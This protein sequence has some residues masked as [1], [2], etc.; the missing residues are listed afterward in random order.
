VTTGQQLEA[1][2]QHPGI[3]RGVRSRPLSPALMSD[4][5]IPVVGKL[6][7]I[8]ENH[9]LHFRGVAGRSSPRLE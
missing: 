4:F 1:G 9:A 6:R 8:C 2:N 5:S 7:P 3:A